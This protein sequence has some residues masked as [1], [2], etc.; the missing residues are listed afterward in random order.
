MNAVKNSLFADY[1]GFLNTF[2]KIGREIVKIE[3]EWNTGQDYFKAQ[4][5]IDNL[6]QLDSQLGNIA[7]NLKMKDDYKT[8]I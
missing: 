8:W 5:Y 7:F 3:R 1:I 4:E 2:K 6:H